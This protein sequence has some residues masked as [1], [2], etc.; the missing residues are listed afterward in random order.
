MFKKKD[1]HLKAAGLDEAREQTEQ[2]YFGSSQKGSISRQ[3]IILIILLLVVG[4]AALMMTGKF[5]APIPGL[6][7]SADE[8]LHNLEIEMIKVKSL[9]E[10]ITFLEITVAKKLGQLQGQDGKPL[11]DEVSNLSNRLDELEKKVSSAG[12]AKKKSR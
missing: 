9:Q 3:G 5:N 2:S 11:K 6:G 7:K 1:R 4:F 8:R 12:S 10:R